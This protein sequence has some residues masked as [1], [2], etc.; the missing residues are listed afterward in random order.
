MDAAHVSIARPQGQV[1][2]LPLLSATIQE[3]ARVA[4]LIQAIDLRDRAKVAFFA[5]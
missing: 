1:S 3:T 4:G 5:F 2:N